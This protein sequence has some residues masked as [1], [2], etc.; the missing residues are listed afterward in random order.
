MTKNL[1]QKT[2]FSLTFFASS[3]A[4]A[5]QARPSIYSLAG[6]G[7]YQ[8][9]R[10]NTAYPVVCISGSKEEGIGGSSA[11][12]VF[13][14]PNS[15]NVSWCGKTTSIRISASGNGAKVIYSFPGNAV[16]FTAGFNRSSNREE[17]RIVITPSTSG[18]GFSYMKLLPRDENHYIKQVKV[19]SSRKCMLDR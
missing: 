5:Q 1:I 4:M 9:Y 7:C 19:F 3:M 11:T 12:M 6:D 10:P 15:T 14:G 16:T 2:L 17:G 8:M 13:V 18:Q